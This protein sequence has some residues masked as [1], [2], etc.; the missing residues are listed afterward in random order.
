LYNFRGF[1]GKYDVYVQD[2]HGK[3]VKRDIHI[4]KNGGN[5]FKIVVE[6]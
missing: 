3:T 4:T 5:K 6:D 2:S 1:H